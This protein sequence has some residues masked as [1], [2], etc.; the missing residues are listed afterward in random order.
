MGTVRSA[1]SCLAYSD[2][3]LISFSLKITFDEGS[4]GKVTNS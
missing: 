2:V 4:T 1:V 3:S